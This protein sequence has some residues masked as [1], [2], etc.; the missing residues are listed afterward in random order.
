MLK[1]AHRLAIRGLMGL[2]VAG[3]LAACTEDFEF[4]SK[5][6]GPGYPCYFDEDCAMGAGFLCDDV[7]GAP[8]PVCTG[9]SLEGEPC[10]QTVA[11][12]YVRDE[13]GLPLQCGPDWTC[14]FPGAAPTTTEDETAP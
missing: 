6:G 11:C 7:Q 12:A 4:P 10:S 8:F 2:L 13:R 9:T 5:G 3:A 14:V 1:R